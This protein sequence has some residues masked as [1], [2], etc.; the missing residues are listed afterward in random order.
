[1][2]HTASYSAILAS[3]FCLPVLGALVSGVLGLSFPA[4]ILPVVLAALIGAG[5]GY[6]LHTKTP[7]QMQESHTAMP[8]VQAPAP[9]TSAAL[10][11]AEPDP[12]LRHDIKG[13]IS[14]AMLAIEQLETST[15]PT[16]QKAA[17]TVNASFDRLLARLKQ[18]S[19]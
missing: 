19:S 10:S 14:P 8:P 2:R 12:K 17:T 7:P 1:M 6:F 13:I 11:G 16:V 5:I 3:L 9:I 15:D 18:R 4:G